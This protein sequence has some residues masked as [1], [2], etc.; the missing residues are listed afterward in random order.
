MRK[1]IIALLLVSGL[2]NA[3][4]FKSEKPVVCGGI[5][6][7]L[8]SLQGDP[9][10][11]KPVWMGKD[12]KDRTSYILLANFK[13]GTWTMIEMNDSVACVLGAGTGHTL[14]LTNLGDPV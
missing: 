3:A 1:M 9:Y 11:E 5:D 2:A 13:T 8:E 4:A 12:I 6:E 7:I 10:S 14:V